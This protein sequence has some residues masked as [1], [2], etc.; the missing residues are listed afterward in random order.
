MRVFYLYAIKKLLRTC[1]PLKSSLA[2]MCHLPK[3]F[4]LHAIPSAFRLVF[5][6]NYIRHV[7]PISE[8][9]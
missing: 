7:G 9:V 6:V 3:F 8:N 4:Y 5:T 2:P 1:V